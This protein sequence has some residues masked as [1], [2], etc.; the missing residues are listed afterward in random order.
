MRIG[1]SWRAGSRLKPPGMPTIGPFGAPRGLFLCAPMA[2]PGFWAARNIKSSN[3]IGGLRPAGISAGATFGKTRFGAGFSPGS[4]GTVGYPTNGNLS[5]PFSIEILFMTGSTL[6]STEVGGWNQAVDGSSG[7]HD[8]D[9][10]FDSSSRLTAYTYASSFATDTTTTYA[11]N[12]LYHAVATLDGTTLR[13]YIN[14]YQVATVAATGS[15]NS[16][17]SSAFWC[18][19]AGGFGSSTHITLLSNLADVCWTPA[20]VMG[21]ALDPFGF[22]EWADDWAMNFEAGAVAAASQAP[23]LISW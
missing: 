12:T 22:L 5:T 19:G 14:G 1:P 8:K 4:T 9:I 10:Y 7:A 16:Y 20:E 6:A 21:R 18:V 15:Y 13:L 17:G 23:Y 3:A 11:T 2:S